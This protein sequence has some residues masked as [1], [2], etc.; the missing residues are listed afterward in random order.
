[1]NDL[2][3]LYLNQGKYAQA[4]ALLREANNSHQKNMTNTWD[5][6][7][8]QSLLGASLAGQKKYVEAEG[9]LLSGYDGMVQR[10][11]TIPAASRFKLEQAGEWIVRLY[12]DWGKPEKAAEWT[13]KLHRIKVASS[14]K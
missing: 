12:Q 1:M 9:L 7:N 8:C 5:R 13:Q 4:A 10:K 3:L 2:S 11:A 6:N 14:P